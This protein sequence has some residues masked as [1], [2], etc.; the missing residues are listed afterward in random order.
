MKKRKLII[1]AAVLVLAGLLTAAVYKN[2]EAQKGS[3]GSLSVKKSNMEEPAALEIN[4]KTSVLL[5]KLCGLFQ[6][7]SQEASWP[8]HLKLRVYDLTD[9]EAQADFF[10]NG[11]WDGDDDLKGYQRTLE[12]SYGIDELLADAKAKLEF[13]S[14]DAEEFDLWDNKDPKWKEFKWKKVRLG[15]EAA[16]C[17]HGKAV[18]S[19]LYLTETDIAEKLE[20]TGFPG[21]TRWMKECEDEWRN[22]LDWEIRSRCFEG[23]RFYYDAMEGLRIECYNSTFFLRKPLKDQ[24]LKHLTGEWTV[25]NCSAGGGLSMAELFSVWK[26]KED[27]SKNMKIYYEQ[28]KEGLKARILQIKTLPAPDNN[29]WT[30]KAD[31][32]QNK[33]MFPQGQLSCTAGFMEE[34]GIGRGEALRFLRKLKYNYEEESGT[35]GNCRYTLKKQGPSTFLGDME[36]NADVHTITIARED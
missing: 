2:V 22:K 19:K 15:V 20:E 13:C 26:E 27:Y 5:G 6:K 31:M 1:A 16:F 8:E 11:F 14:E 34:L 10:H 28:E 29:D 21:L 35:I 23:F 25:G 18:A 17:S 4:E 7:R 3:F 32:P 36:A 9:K 30:M 12:L 33:T 24:I